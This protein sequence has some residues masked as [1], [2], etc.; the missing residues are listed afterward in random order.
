M[1]PIPEQKQSPPSLT[2][3]QALVR[4]DME[5]VNG[6]ILER[7]TQ[8]VA[9]INDIARHIIASGGKRLRP[10][11]TIACAKLCGYEGRHHL[12]LAASVE[13][14]H[15]ATLL[16][17]DVVDAST[18]R[19]GDKTAN[20]IW[21]NQASVLVGDFLLSRAFQLMV[22]TGSL[23][24]LRRLSDASAT[25]SQG[26]V[27]QLST[28]NEPATT[29][30]QYLEVISAKTA[31]LFAAACALGAIITDKGEKEREA[32]E[33]FGLHL[34]IAFQLVDDA[35]DYSARESELGKT[36]G[37]DFREGKITLPVILAYRAADREEK[38]FWE[39]TV[40]DLDQR[41]GDLAHALTLMQKHQ[42]LRATISLASEYCETAAKAMRS[43]PNSPARTALHEVLEFCVAREY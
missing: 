35:L 5:Q 23:G 6:V 11:L 24:V 12:L 31:A 10:A 13:L 19:R 16:H 42:T 32:L 30:E 29:Q 28:A 43:F 3:L 18:M 9:L 41:E 15:T 1:Q 37:D 8:D 17:D 14:I 21:T 26:E 2:A 36:V 40:G 34:G 39:R 4:K 25:I 7:V 38:A 27:L 20:V 22:D 33:R